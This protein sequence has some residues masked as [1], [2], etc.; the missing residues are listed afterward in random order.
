MGSLQPFSGVSNDTGTNVRHHQ[1]RWLLEPGWA[2]ARE[3]RENQLNFYEYNHWKVITYRYKESCLQQFIQAFIITCHIFFN[4]KR[5]GFFF[6]L[7]WRATRAVP[8]R[9]PAWRGVHLHIKMLLEIPPSS[10]GTT[11]W[12]WGWM[13]TRRARCRHVLH[14]AV[15]SW[16]HPR[17]GSTVNWGFDSKT[18]NIL[19][20]PTV[21]QVN[22]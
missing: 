4:K 1:W 6:I 22:G 21:S 10:R 15:P 8:F 7:I 16:A 5:K 11:V 2:H 12:D 13:E 14:A 20:M 18:C 19:D 9:Q 17:M 3:V